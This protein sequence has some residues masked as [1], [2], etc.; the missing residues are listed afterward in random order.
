AVPVNYIGIRAG[1]A[2]GAGDRNRHFVHPHIGPKPEQASANPHPNTPAESGRKPAALKAILPEAL[3]Q[4]LLLDCVSVTRA[5]RAVPGPP[6]GADAGLARLL[7][8]LARRPP[9]AGG[10]AP[11]ARSTFAQRVRSLRFAG[12]AR[13]ARS[14]QGAVPTARSQSIGRSRVGCSA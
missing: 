12:S 3:H 1:E 11:S 13:N 9:R 8:E 5:R 2:A 10:V 6:V 4:W 14:R 7:D